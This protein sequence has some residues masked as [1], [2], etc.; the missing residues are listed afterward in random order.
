MPNVDGGAGIRV[1][2]VATLLAL[3][4]GQGTD[5]WASDESATARDAE[6]PKVVSLYYGSDRVRDSNGYYVGGTVALNGDIDKSGFVL[7]G[8]VGLGDY[9]YATTGVPGGIVEGESTQLNGL[10]G[11]QISQ[12][13]FGG[14]LAVGVDYLNIELSPD[15]PGATAKGSE[16]GFI[17][18]GDLYILFPMQRGGESESSFKL[19]FSGS[20]STV[21]DS[22]WTRVRVGYDSERFAIGPEGIA[23]GGEDYEAQRLGGFVTYKHSLLPG[24]SSEISVSMGHQFV[25]NG[26]GGAGTFENRGGGEGFY[27]SVSSSLSF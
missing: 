18:S 6:R 13:N 9:E 8:A 1:V 7:K 2:A 5:V 4:S 21:Y 15:D 11:Y 24:T 23:M 27:A 20:Y 16:T 14:S 17:T 19:E 10:I 12:E 26:N 3:V 25:P 22:Y